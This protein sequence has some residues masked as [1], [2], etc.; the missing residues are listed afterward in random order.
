MSM[1]YLQAEGE[2]QPE[3]AK[4]GQTVSFL[5]SSPEKVLEPQGH[6]KWGNKQRSEHG[7]PF[8]SHS[9]DFWSL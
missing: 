1:V 4:G 2:S 3:K 7:L 5:H 9:S 8:L 6:G